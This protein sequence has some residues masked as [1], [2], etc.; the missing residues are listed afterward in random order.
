MHTD[1]VETIILPL[2]F[3]IWWL[4][5]PI[6]GSTECCLL[7]VC[8]SL[9]VYGL[10]SGLVAACVG[11]NR[12]SEVAGIMEGIRG[13]GL[14]WHLG[15]TQIPAGLDP[16]GNLISCNRTRPDWDSLLFPCRRLS[17]FRIRLS[18]P[19][20]PP[21]LPIPSKWVSALSAQRCGCCKMLQ[22]AP[23]RLWLLALP[24]RSNGV[25]N[26]NFRSHSEPFK[27]SC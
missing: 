8:L 27:V 5:P 9:H 19:Q 16:L 4:L 14:G 11:V 22:A 3:N 15:F 17:P 18:R 2:L 24:F 7:R 21:R 10:T 20:P 13:E 6:G 25:Q 1:N 12:I 26:I 23:P